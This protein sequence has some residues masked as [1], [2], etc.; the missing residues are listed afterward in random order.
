MANDPREAIMARLLIVIGQASG[1]SNVSRN[2]LYDDDAADTSKRVTLLEGDEIAA[3]EENLSR[4]A[5]VGRLIQMHPHVEL[6][7]FNTADRVGAGLSAARA[8]I[9]KAVAA[10]ATL[11]SLTHKN[12]GGR[13]VG[14]ESD[15][16]FAREMLGRMTPK[17]Q[18]T[19]AL[20]PSLL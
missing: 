10:D 19:Y 12:T 8:A 5:G 6:S 3:E 13:Y 11:I 4:P 16:G 2:Q 20:I 7:N 14:M 9:I 15:L 18:F 1:V 17:F